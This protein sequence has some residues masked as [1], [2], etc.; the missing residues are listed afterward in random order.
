[1]SYRDKKDKAKRKRNWKRQQQ[2]QTE[3]IGRQEMA[4]GHSIAQRLER[5][6][7]GGYAAI[8]ERAKLAKEES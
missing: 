8:R 6:D 7:R 2:R 5:L 3:A 4:S 1:M